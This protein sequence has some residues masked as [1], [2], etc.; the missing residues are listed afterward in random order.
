MI[1]KI[2]CEFTK[3]FF[4]NISTNELVK[5]ANEHDIMHY[6]NPIAPQ[7]I[8]GLK[9]ITKPILMSVRSHRWLDLARESAPWVHMHVI[10]PALH[11]VFPEATLIPNGIFEQFKPDHVFT[12][13][14]AGKANEYKGFDLIREACKQAGAIFRPALDIEP[15]Q[16]LNYFRSIDLYVCASE[17]EGHSTPVMEC[18]AMNKPVITVDVGLP[19]TLNVHKVE[20]TV[21]SI[22]RGIERFNTA[23]QVKQFNWENTCKQIHALYQRLVDGQV[24]NS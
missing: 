24:H 16:M 6:Q 5:I 11:Q 8:P 9:D 22:R 20:R 3:R 12:V 4:S 13:G 1:R 14:F 7:H 18:L 17:N 10:T 15:D 2:P 19:S 23:P 21:E